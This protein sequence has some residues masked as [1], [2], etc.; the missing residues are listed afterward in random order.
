MLQSVWN[1]LLYIKNELLK[2]DSIC[3]DLFIMFLCR[4]YNPAVGFMES[5]A[6]N[7]EVKH[8]LGNLCVNKEKL[9]TAYHTP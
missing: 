8:M 2:A 5:C 3:T 4:P 9:I 1:F 7:G 6:W